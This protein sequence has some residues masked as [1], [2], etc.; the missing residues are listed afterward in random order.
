MAL[1]DTD[2]ITDDSYITGSGGGFGG[3]DTDTDSDF[4]SRGGR[5]YTIVPS[6]IDIEVSGNNPAATTSVYCP[7]KV[8]PDHNGF[9]SYAYEA[10]GITTAANRGVTAFFKEIV[11]IVP[12]K[13]IN[14]HTGNS[15][16][17]TENNLSEY[18]DKIKYNYLSDG[19]KI[20]S[21]VHN[22]RFHQ[23]HVFREIE[24]KILFKDGIYHTV[25][26]II[27]HSSCLSGKRGV[28]LAKRAPWAFSSDPAVGHTQRNTTRIGANKFFGNLHPQNIADGGTSVLGFYTYSY[29]D[30]KFQ[31]QG[32]ML[33]S[34]SNRDFFQLCYT[35]YNILNLQ[36][37]STSLLHGNVIVK[38]NAVLYELRQL[39][40]ADYSYDRPGGITGGNMFSNSGSFS[41]SET[42]NPFRDI[43]FN[44]HRRTDI[45][46]PQIERGYKSV[47]F[48]HTIF[49][50]IDPSGNFSPGVQVETAS[51]HSSGF[52]NPSLHTLAN[53]SIENI[54]KQPK[55]FAGSD[56]S[57]GRE[58]SNAFYLPSGF[59]Y[60]KNNDTAR[61]FDGIIYTLSKEDGTTWGG[62]SDGV[63]SASNG[64]DTKYQHFKGVTEVLM[65]EAEKYSAASSIGSYGSTTWGASPN[66]NAFGLV[67]TNLMSPQD[68]ISNFILGRHTYYLSRPHHLTNIETHQNLLQASCLASIFL[69]DPH[70]DYR[71]SADPLLD[72][73]NGSVS[74]GLGMSLNNLSV[75]GGGRQRV[76][77]QGLPFHYYIDSFQNIEI[78][79]DVSFKKGFD[80]KGVHRPAEID[81][82]NQLHFLDGKKDGHTIAVEKSILFS[83]KEELRNDH[84]TLYGKSTD[85]SI[86]SLSTIVDDVSLPNQ[87]DYD[88]YVPSLDKNSVFWSQSPITLPIGRGAL[89]NRVLRG[90]AYSLYSS[91]SQ[92]IEAQ[93]NTK[94]FLKLSHEEAIAAITQTGDIQ[95][96]ASADERGEYIRGCINMPRGLS[97][98][99]S[100]FSLDLLVAPSLSAGLTLT[101]L[102]FKATYRVDETAI[103]SNAIHDSIAPDPDG[104][105]PELISC[106]CA[107]SF[108]NLDWKT[109]GG[110]SFDNDNALSIF[111]FKYTPGRNSLDNSIYPINT[112]DISPGTIVNTEGSD[113]QAKI[114][115]RT[116]IL[117]MDDDVST[118]QDRP[119]ID[120]GMGS[121]FEWSSQSKYISKLEIGSRARSVV[122][123]FGSE[124]ADASIDDLFFSP[125]QFE[126]VA[127]GPELF[128]GG[129]VEEDTPGCTDSNAMNYNSA[130][131]ADNG[132]C[133]YC[134]L[135]DKLSGFAN[136]LETERPFDMLGGLQILPQPAI[137][138]A[139]TPFGMGSWYLN[140][141]YLFGS[142]FNGQIGNAHNHWGPGLD[143]AQTGAEF[144]A[145]PYG[146]NFGDLANPYTQFA[147]SCNFNALNVPSEPTFAAFINELLSSGS[148]NAEDWTLSFYK[149]ESWTGTEGSQW[150][151][152][153][154][155]SVP[156]LSD[157]PI[158]NYSTTPAIGVMANQG[159][160][161]NPKFGSYDLN[162]LFAPNASDFLSSPYI[163]TYLAPGYHYVAVLNLSIRG[164]LTGYIDPD[165]KHPL[166]CPKSIAIPFNFWVTF[167]G[168]SS[169][170]AD[171]YVGDLF[172][173]PWS[174]IGGTP[175]PSGYTDM[176]E[177]RIQHG[178]RKVRRTDTD[179][180][181][182]CDLPDPF[183]CSNF[184]DL[185]VTT[186]AAE[187]IPSPTTNSPGNQEFQGT[188]T[189]SVFGVYTNMEGGDEYTFILGG[190]LFTFNLYLYL[191]PDNSDPLEVI[192]FSTQEDYINYGFNPITDNELQISFANLE[193]GVYTI[194]LEQTN[195]FSFQDSPCPS[196]ALQSE[197]LTLTGGSDECPDLLTGCTDPEAAN[198]CC[199][200]D[201]GLDVDSV[202]EDGTCEY[203]D[204]EDIFLSGEISNIN[205]VNTTIDCV[206]TQVSNDPPVS[207]NT[208]VD[209]QVGEFSIPADGYNATNFDSFVVG[210]CQVFSGNSGAAVTTLFDSYASQ[211]AEIIDT[212][213]N[214][215]LVISTDTL[216]HIGGWLPF[217]DNGAP[218]LATYLPPATELVTD[219]SFTALGNELITDGDFSNAASW[220]VGP[221]WTI[222][223][224]AGTATKTSVNTSLEQEVNELIINQNR[225]YKISF[226][227][228]TF[229]SGTLIV[230]VGDVASQSIESAAGTGV[231]TLY[232][233]AFGTQLVKFYGNFVGV[234]E[235]V[236]CKEIGADWVVVGAGLK[237][238]GYATFIGVG[239]TLNIGGATLQQQINLTSSLEYQVKFKAR[240]ISGTGKMYSSL[241][242]TPVFNQTITAEFVEYS[243][244][245][246]A[247]VVP[248]VLYPRINFGGET[249]STFEIKDISLIQTAQVD[250]LGPSLAGG[251][252]VVMIFPTYPDVTGSDC[253]P[254]IINHFDSLF[255]ITIN[256]TLNF[257][258]C[259]T[260]CNYGPCDDWD[261]G[262]TDE[263]ATNYDPDADYDDGSCHYDGQEDCLQNPEAPGCEDCTTAAELN[264]PSNRDCDEWDGSLEGCTDPNAC[265][266]D[267]LAVVSVISRCEYCWCSDDEDCEE[268]PV[269]DECEDENGNILPDCVQPECPD[270]TN[271][272]C[273]EPVV[274][275]CPAD[276]DCP[277]PPDPECVILGNCVG[278][279]EDENP[280]GDVIIEEEIIQEV[281]C[282][283]GLGNHR[284]FDGVRAAAMTCSATEGSKLFFKLRSGV[285][286]DKTDLIK[287]TLINYLFNFAINE[288]CM[289]SCDDDNVVHQ[290]RVR[291]DKLGCKEKWKV[292]GYQVW[293]SQSSFKKGTTV[294]VLKLESGVNKMHFYTAISSVGAGEPHPTTKLGTKAGTKW[295]PCITT[296]GKSS[297]GQTPYVYKLYE[298]MAKFCEQ[299]N[300]YSTGNT[301]DSNFEI[302]EP[303]E[304]SRPSGLLDENG[305]EIKL[306]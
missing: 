19:N 235:D 294:A 163:Q 2:D 93:K 79:S 166:E 253:V 161:I 221:T 36:S 246:E 228:S 16:I 82:V 263:N 134:D 50:G 26:Q 138:P 27:V 283:P 231:K 48:L 303:Q 275:P 227:I 6:L 101:E 276:V 274:D 149:I 146:P 116:F 78:T 72:F 167:C 298:F 99:E 125:Q 42:I 268:G 260:P 11:G 123:Q 209:N 144:P 249:G 292:G 70:P 61:R 23:D 106:G 213:R 217:D 31:S 103:V 43:I 192:S 239:E 184:I 122:T 243:Y 162:M 62:S 83:N 25:K 115:L 94:L 205:T 157:I 151:A 49:S 131:T 178:A 219:G 278:G 172:D 102:Q 252:Y 14:Y 194:V 20:I 15:I 155:V 290:T 203:V 284:T 5:H 92:I 9:A 200:P 258:D 195:T 183:S 55:G 47:D 130:A 107:G 88:K 285:K 64:K 297:N 164:I 269:I 53:A 257:T 216:G 147:F 187:C 90:D 302:I 67:Q 59:N 117:N 255:F 40:G 154:D 206:V 77:L 185:C 286:Y 222:D 264:L 124:A 201:T 306:F 305:N 226:N 156:H 46:L 51:S 240:I 98:D 41:G 237:Q 273:D 199:G 30:A 282:L 186:T 52:V 65:T 133:L 289:S 262:C 45:P 10:S 211:T 265:N 181:G 118:E 91:A 202:I 182:F 105:N 177:C 180:G 152:Q 279:G 236:S 150:G 29:T 272:A 13:I 270:P 160:A 158:L 108:S 168:C 197:T 17:L 68:A 277:G 121:D 18:I 139:S 7:F 28:E 254:E 63:S 141:N 208:L 66:N 223:T 3:P 129:G 281:S 266:Y 224:S 207:I 198:Y 86:L 22:Q 204:C 261:P 120:V 175:F 100:N 128:D 248:G 33:P 191:T 54:L 126:F 153:Y 60:R 193:Q 267:P 179:W 84:Y 110:A 89:T 169:Y 299:C 247:A 165:T 21:I 170:D 232:F 104:G 196:I 212:T 301:Y 287:L 229:T 215:T 214:Q 189:T 176:E 44:S 245:M 280:D 8:M 112:T 1:I 37:S 142:W 271:P 75:P 251:Y 288:S 225:W 291:I 85:Y 241:D 69:K 259:E 218:I 127:I 132:S 32:E 56:G 34:Q 73:G 143:V 136:M 119:L 173:Y 81:R 95:T 96:S 109:A 234:I 137:N 293:T 12:T 233:M 295:S 304:D 174:G 113:P 87:W 159:T 238:E 80:S 39:S 114:E 71:L 171:N 145:V 230:E 57:L 38:S 76:R 190:E 35:N 296:R 140:S 242:V 210:Y 74:K 256:S 135:D 4:V 220:T 250:T 24:F 111:R 148:F 58:K 244:I 300:V 97:D 188:I